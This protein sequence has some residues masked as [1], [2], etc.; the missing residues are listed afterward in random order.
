MPTILHKFKDHQVAADTEILILGTFS[1]DT[2]EGTDFFYGRSRNFLWH[3]LPQCWAREP[4]KEAGLEEKKRF[5][6][7]RK[8]DFADLIH[9]IDVPEGEE[10]NVDDAFI[11]SQ[12]TEWKNIIGIMESLP[13]LKAV[14]FT[15]KT[16]NGIPNTKKHLGPIVDYCR[17]KN[18][19]ICKLETPAKFYSP[20]KLQQWKDTIVSGKTCLKP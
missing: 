17:Q 3:L 14:Y 7:E 6:T 19:R 10:K 9:A 1:G 13:K 2:E 18:I 12:A 16:F 20:E 15:R 11:D 5:M 8:V 4:L